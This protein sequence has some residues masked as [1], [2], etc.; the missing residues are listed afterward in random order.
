MRRRR[1][2][3]PRVTSFRQGVFEPRNPGKYIGNVNNI[4]YRSSWE[5]N[6]CKFLDNNPNVLKWASEEI[7]IPYIKPTTG[8][9][10]RYYPDFYMEYI[11]KRGEVVK[12][13]IE[14][15]P[16]KQTRSSTAKRNK[17]RLYE[18]ITFA[19]NKAKWIAAEKWCR[20]RGVHFRILTENQL[21][22]R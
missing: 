20:Q 4:T 9:Q 22:K 11:N 13:L 17:T 3:D 16:E 12:E 14:I 18:D 1:S 7:T 19:I 15:K 21:F 2:K 8:R 5:L 10:H 6:F